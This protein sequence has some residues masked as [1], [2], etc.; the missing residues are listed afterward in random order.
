MPID[1]S[2]RLPDLSQGGTVTVGEIVDFVKAEV[3][4]EALAEVEQAVLADLRVLLGSA[5]PIKPAG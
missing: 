2:M 4:K 5:R 1:R 3:V